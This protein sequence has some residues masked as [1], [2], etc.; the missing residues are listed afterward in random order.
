ML[1][2]ESAAFRKVFRSRKFYLYFFLFGIFLVV[3]I[4]YLIIDAL[5]PDKRESLIGMSPAEVIKQFYYAVNS[6]DL[7]MVQDCSNSQNINMLTNRI[8][9]ITFR[10][11]T[12]YRSNYFHG[13]EGDPGDELIPLMLPEQWISMGKPELQP[14][15]RVFGILI[16]SITEFAANKF[17]VE[18]DFYD[19]DYSDKSNIQTPDVTGYV[20]ICEMEKENG[21]WIINNIEQVS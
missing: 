10:E 9:L 16:Y 1:P 15:T 11:Y 21:V 6:F 12:I 20:D 13:V 3:V 18:Y 5:I 4:P 8:F 2:E 19:T 7:N 17:R 14:G